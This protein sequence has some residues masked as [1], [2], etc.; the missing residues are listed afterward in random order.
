VAE[1]YDWSWPLEDDAQ[2]GVEAMVRA[3]GPYVRASDDLRPRV[4]EAARFQRG[5][6]WARRCIRHVAVFTMLMAFFTAADQPGLDGRRSRPTAM[7]AAAG[8][9]EFLT[10]AT[11]V[12][13]RS[14]DGDWRM[15]EAFT[16]LR[17]QQAQ[18][19]RLA[20]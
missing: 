7:L 4:L 16:E 3:A 19:L 14:G 13:P 8:F 11:T 5:E 17:R 9:D 1:S 6:Q 10:P 18:M 12:T 20:L 2:D 15:I